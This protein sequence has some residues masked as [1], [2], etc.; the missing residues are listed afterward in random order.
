M[1]PQIAEGHRAGED[2]RQVVFQGRLN[3]LV[4]RDHLRARLRHVHGEIPVGICGRLDV[5]G[6]LL[7]AFLHVV[8]CLGFFLFH[9]G[10]RRGHP[11]NAVLHGREIIRDGTEPVGRVGD[12]FLPRRQ[13]HCRLGGLVLR[14]HQLDGASRRERC[15]P[16]GIQVDLSGPPH[17]FRHAPERLAGVHDRQRFFFLRRQQVV[18]RV[19]RGFQVFFVQEIGRD[20][21]RHRQQG[22]TQRGQDG[23]RRRIQG[24]R[25]RR[26][27]FRNQFL[28]FEHPAIG[29]HRPPRRGDRHDRRLQTIGKL[30]ARFAS[31]HPGNPGGIEQHEV[32]GLR[33]NPRLCDRLLRRLR[34]SLTGLRRL[35]ERRDGLFGPRRG[36]ANLDIRHLRHLRVCP[37]SGATRLPRRARRRTL[38]LPSSEMRGPTRAR[39]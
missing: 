5:V 12:V 38:R 36:D 34:E 32:K 19:L 15:R 25:R 3:R 16:G 20:H 14:T 9:R 2:P 23:R 28:R 21:P 30:L 7:Q 39:T 27:G 13:H 22:Q 18:E 17:H 24:D 4:Q 35:V 33:G 8:E 11:F 1:R 26:H 31:S 37:P 29:G 6:H 10:E